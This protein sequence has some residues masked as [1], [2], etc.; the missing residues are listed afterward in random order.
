MEFISKELLEYCESFSEKEEILLKELNR[1]THLK[2]NSPRMLSGPLQGRFLSFLSKMIKPKYALEIGTYTGYSAL[3]I[4]E[5]VVE[6]G[7][8]FTIDPNEETNAFAAQFISKTKKKE[9]KP[10]ENQDK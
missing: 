6:G 10:K 9:K 2:V 1:E 7:K 4:A 3:C 8:L 5:G